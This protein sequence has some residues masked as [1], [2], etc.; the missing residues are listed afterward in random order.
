MP[1][2]AETL[3][4]E[5]SL[6][7]GKTGVDEVILRAGGDPRKA[8]RALLVALVEQRR[9]RATAEGESSLGYRRGLSPA[10]GS[11]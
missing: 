1:D 6:S 3:F 11:Q 2:A 4:E 5:E 7:G 10:A 8:I 9:A